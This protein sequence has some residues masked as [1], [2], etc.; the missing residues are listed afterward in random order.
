MSSRN[1]SYRNQEI[2]LP[3]NMGLEGPYGKSEIIEINKEKCELYYSYDISFAG[4]AMEITKSIL[5]MQKETKATI[6]SVVTIIDGENG[7]A[8]ATFKIEQ[9]N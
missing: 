3:D 8:S 6:A 5:D 7:V 1:E 4:N 9:K 2:G